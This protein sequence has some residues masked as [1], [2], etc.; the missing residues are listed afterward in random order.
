MYSFNGAYQRSFDGRY[1]C[2]STKAKS[3]CA[4]VPDEDYLIP[5]M[6]SIFRF[7]DNYS[8]SS[9]S[10]YQADRILMSV[11]EGNEY[12]PPEYKINQINWDDN[13]PALQAT[14]T[15][16]VEGEIAAKIFALFDYSTNPKIVIDNDKEYTVFV[17][18]VLPN[19]II[20]QP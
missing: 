4:Y 18:P 13:L 5:P 12:F 6:K 1:L 8:P 9:L 7:L 14:P 15:L 3:I 11:I 20:G 2:V 17:R 10:L 19:E 16:F